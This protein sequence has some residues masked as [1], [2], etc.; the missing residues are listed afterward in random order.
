MEDPY[1]KRENLWAAALIAIMLFGLTLPLIGTRSAQAAQDQAAQAEELKARV[2]NYDIRDDVSEEAQA[3]KAKHR[4]KLSPALREKQINLGQTMRNAKD[5]LAA[6]IPGLEV[7]QSNAGA[8]E[9]VGVDSSKKS[10]LT[11]P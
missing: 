2:S 11:D 1:M 3:N 6:Q 5:R 4:Q 7:K 8:A 9:I 10:F